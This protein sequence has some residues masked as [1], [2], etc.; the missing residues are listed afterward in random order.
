[1]GDD[2]A[3]DPDKGVRVSDYPAM[4]YRIKGLFKEVQRTMTYQVDKAVHLVRPP[5]LSWGWGLAVNPV[6]KV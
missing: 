6:E 3:P 5:Q 2:E 1:M 4:C